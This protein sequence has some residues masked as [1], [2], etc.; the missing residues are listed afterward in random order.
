[1]VFSLSSY[2]Q[3]IGIN[4]LDPQHPLDVNGN[5]NVDGNILLNNIAGESGQIMTTNSAGS[6]IW[7][8]RSEFKH[9]I[10]I[11][12]S[13]SWTVPANVDHI[14]LEMWGGGGGGSAGGGGA[15]GMYTISLLDVVPS[16]TVTVVV[17]LGGPDAVNS[18]SAASPGGNSSASGSFGTIQAAG[19]NG[20]FSTT[21]ANSTTYGTFGA[22]YFQFP[23]QNGFA[24][25]VSYQ[26]KNATTF[27]VVTK[28]GDGGAAGPDYSRRCGGQIIIRNESTG[29]VL[30]SN[31]VPTAPVPGGGGGGGIN[32][33]DGAKGMVVIYY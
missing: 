27:A 33:R 15:A 8:D 31:S 23:G 19:G 9:L 2:C 6:T 7:A 5:I 3:N 12:Q 14:R 18:I 4:N 32:S 29:G 10:G 28:Y 17:G 16:S 13:T 20:A 1:M 25:T 26:Q 21:P 30:E 11:T 24:N 22:Q